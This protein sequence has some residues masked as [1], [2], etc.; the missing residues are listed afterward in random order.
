VQSKNEWNEHLAA[1]H[2]R[3]VFIAKVGNIFA[4]FNPGGGSQE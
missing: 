3:F 1:F 4:F 2:K